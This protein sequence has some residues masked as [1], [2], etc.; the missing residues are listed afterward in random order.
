MALILPTNFID[1]QSARVFFLAGPVLG[2]GD[3]QHEAIKSLWKSEMGA[4]IVCPVRYPETHELYKYGLSGSNPFTRQAEWERYYLELASKQGCILFWLPEESKLDPRPAGNGPYARDTY[5]ELGEWRMRMKFEKARV[6]IG[7]E[8]GFPGASVTSF[9][10]RAVL[11]DTFD[12]ENSL[13]DT[14][15]AAIKMARG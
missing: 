3:W 6:V 7:M 11:G 14:V 12:F 5:Q 1:V 8:R 4:Y 10:F 9:N 15:Q 2:G 13:E